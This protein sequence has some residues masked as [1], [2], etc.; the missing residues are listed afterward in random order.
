MPSCQT[1]KGNATIGF[2]K[3]EAKHAKNSSCQ[4]EANRSMCA[5]THLLSL[6]LKFKQYIYMYSTL[7]VSYDD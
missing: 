4:E 3:R 6:H 1:Y 2:A 5:D 7:A